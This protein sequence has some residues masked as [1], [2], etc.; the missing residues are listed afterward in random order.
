MPINALFDEHLTDAQNRGVVVYP[1]LYMNPISKDT[2]NVSCKI[3]HHVAEQIIKRV[4]TGITAKAN[5]RNVT[6]ISYYD[7][8]TRD[9]KDHGVGGDGLAAEPWNFGDGCS[10]SEMLYGYGPDVL[11]FSDY[12]FDPAGVPGVQQTPDPHP[13]EAGSEAMADEVV[14]VVNGGPTIP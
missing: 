14:R 1:T 2:P 3:N 13:N 8:W 10:F 4:N 11:N 7:L 12:G 9:G 5:E 6:P